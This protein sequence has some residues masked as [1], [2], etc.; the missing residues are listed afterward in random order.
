LRV[1]HVLR[2]PT[3]YYKLDPGEMGIA[4]PAKASE[5]ILRVVAH[6]LGNIHRFVAEAALEGG[7]VVYSNISLDLAF[8]GS[9]LA[10][11]A[12]KSEARII[13]KKRGR[14]LILERLDG[15][16]EDRERIKSHLRREIIILEGKKEATKR[17]LTI[18]FSSKRRRIEDLNRR[19]KD[20]E[21]TLRMLDSG[22]SPFPPQRVLNLLI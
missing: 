20:L 11:R 21:R 19:I 16:A 17:D 10:A 1:D 14:E 15:S 2:N 12:G 7:I 13:Y 22:L 9:F 8:E 18:D 5:S 3:L 6:E 4:A